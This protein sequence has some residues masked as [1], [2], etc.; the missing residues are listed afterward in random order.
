MASRGSS[1]CVSIQSRTL[2]GVD[3]QVGGD[4]GAGGGALVGGLPA[5]GLGAARALL[6][7]EVRR[8]SLDEGASLV[9]G[10]LDEV[11]AV[12]RREQAVGALDVV[13]RRADGGAEAA[14]RRSRGRRG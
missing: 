3:L 11:A 1:K 7:R 12:D 13:R 2:P 5:A 10:R 4:A 8:V 14:T 9:G 6:G